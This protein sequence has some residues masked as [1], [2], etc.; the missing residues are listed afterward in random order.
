MALRWW[1]PERDRQ[2]RRCAQ[3]LAP[4]EAQEGTLTFL[5]FSWWKGPLSL[6]ATGLRA[7]SGAPVATM[8]PTCSGSHLP[9][10]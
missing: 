6:G 1:G 7:A 5:P 4:Q 3:R 9:S 8:E 10:V 2:L